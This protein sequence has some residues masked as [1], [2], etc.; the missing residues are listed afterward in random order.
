M[1]GSA[2][3]TPAARQ[4]GRSLRRIGVFSACLPGWS[5]A[6]VV[7]VASSL[8]LSC[9]EWAYGRGQAI[10]RAGAGPQIR[11]LCEAAG[12][13]SGGLA[14]QDPEVTLATPRRAAKHV[15]LA[16]A[17]GAPHVRLLAP[18]YHGGSLRREQERVRT[19]L[20]R[21]VEL[22]APV[23]VAVL[24]E[25]SPTTL[26]PAPELAMSLVERQPP[27]RA[28]VLYDPGNMV[29]EGHLAPAVAIARLGPYLRHVHVKNIAWA[30]RAEVWRW[31]HASLAA[32]ILDWRVIVH[33]LAAARYPGRFSIDH[34]GGEVS[35]R[36]LASESAFLDALVT[37]EAGRWNREGARSPIGA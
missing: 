10:D 18:V 36:K 16:A 6:R 5:A 22:A 30:R 34:L 19:G 25:T 15:A 28:G 37:A 2:M 29:I 14:V 31:R 7:G 8:G 35:A 11:E 27:E 13:Q 33:E 17:L 23:G 1:S 32:G 12:L 9:V 3:I 4:D 20:E 26:A 24:V 21:L